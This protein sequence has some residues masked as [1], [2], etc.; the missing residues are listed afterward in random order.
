MPSSS[1]IFRLSVLR[2]GL[3]LNLELTVRLSGCPVY[4]DELTDACHHAWLSVRAGSPASHGCIQST[5][6]TEPSP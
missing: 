2:H 4:N 1:V 3:S 5:L 6:S